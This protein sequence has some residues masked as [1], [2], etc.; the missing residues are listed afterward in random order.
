M[1]PSTS[2]LP[3]F[4]PLT[5]VAGIGCVVAG[6][7]LDRAP[8]SQWPDAQITQWYGTHGR[9][10]W[11]VSACFIALGA[12]LLIAFTAVV[13]DRLERSGASRFAGQ[14]VSGAGLALAVTYLVGAGVYAA[15]PAAMTFSSAPAPD[16]S[17]SR[18]F[19]GASYG[20]L[21]MFSAFAAALFA[22]SVSVT[23]LR[24]GGLPRW[25]A[26]AG[27]SC[28]GADAAERGDADGGHHV[29]VRRRQRRDVFAP[30][31]RDRRSTRRSVGVISAIH[32]R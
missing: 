30:P 3:R 28:R 10:L 17:T 26:V 24:T 2:P 21:V 32:T 14:L 25:L 27:N 22:T 31:R 12:P 15:V 7:A 13:R 9:F 16:P 20:I 5:G 8:T 29:V 19:L 1:N 11:F 6:L 18:Y 23:A 4:S